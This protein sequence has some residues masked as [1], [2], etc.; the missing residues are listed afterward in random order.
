[1]GTQQSS[2]QYQHWPNLLPEP[3]MGRGHKYAS[4]SQGR[5]ITTT[6]DREEMFRGQ[7]YLIFFLYLAN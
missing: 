4:H 1:M 2:A 7:E 3:W 5:R 6:K